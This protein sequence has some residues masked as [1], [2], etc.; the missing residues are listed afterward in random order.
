MAY[1]SVASVSKNI[2][3]LSITPGSIDPIFL[4]LIGDDERK[5]PFNY[6]RRHSSKMATMA[7]ILDM[8]SVD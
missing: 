5:V 2:W 1:V 3:F 4:W 8:V 7:A 6:Q